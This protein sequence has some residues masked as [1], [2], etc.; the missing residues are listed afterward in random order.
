MVK[1]LLIKPHA[2]LSQLRAAVNSIIKLRALPC[3]TQPRQG[4][5][6]SGVRFA[7]VW[8]G[9]AQTLRPPNP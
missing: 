5:G 8:A 2:S 4:P 6:F 3:G 1:L 9:K 7:S